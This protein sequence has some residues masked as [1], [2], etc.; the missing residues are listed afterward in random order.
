METPPGSYLGP[1]APWGHGFSAGPRVTAV[2]GET[3]ATI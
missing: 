1:T 3:A 2:T